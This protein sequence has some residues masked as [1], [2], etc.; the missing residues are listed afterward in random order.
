[1]SRYLQDD[2][3]FYRPR[4][5]SFAEQIGRVIGIVFVIAVFLF[6]AFGGK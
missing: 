5:P 1:M 3:G 4:R 6:I 2:E